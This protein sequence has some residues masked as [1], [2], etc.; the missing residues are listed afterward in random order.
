MIKASVRF[1]GFILLVLS[2]GISTLPFL[3]LTKISRYKA[4]IPL[5]RILS[6]HAKA[7]LWMINIKSN[8]PHYFNQ[9]DD[10]P[11]ELIVAN[12]LSYVDILIL[13]AFRPSCF[14]TSIEMRNMPFLGQLCELGGCLYVERR[15][16]KNLSNEI[17]DITN[18]LKGGLNVIIF[19]EATSTN[20]EEIK[21]FKRPL[22]KAAI[23]SGSTITPITINYTSLNQKSVTVSNRDTIFWYGDMSFLP[24]FWNLLK[25]DE[26]TAHL[27]LSAQI[28]TSKDEEISELAQRS[29]E[30]VNL[31]YYPIVEAINESVI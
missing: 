11:G 1:I 17:V 26:I 9:I 12:H 15:S 6:L 5:T 8:T 10:T 29:Y 7:L 2:Y 22:F 20:G 19:P 14:V 16:K 27:S 21:R 30:M 31:Y 18:A 24:H 23:D 13:A 28:F 3:F 25:Q 4:R